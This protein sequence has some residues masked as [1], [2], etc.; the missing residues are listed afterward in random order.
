[1]TF[2]FYLFKLKCLFLLY[3]VTFKIV[4]YF[5]KKYY[6]FKRIKIDWAR[7]IRICVWV[8]KLYFLI[9]YGY[10][11]RKIIYSNTYFYIEKLCCESIVF[12][13]LLSTFLLEKFIIFKF[14]LITFRN[15]NFVK[16]E[17]VL[18]FL[19]LL[20]LLPYKTLAF[21]F[22]KVKIVGPEVVI[23]RTPEEEKAWQ[24]QGWRWLFIFTFIMVFYWTS[25]EFI[26]SDIYHYYLEDFFPCELPIEQIEAN[27]DQAIIR[28]RDLRTKTAVIDNMY[29]RKQDEHTK[30]ILLKTKAYY[31][32]MY[33][34]VLKHHGKP[35]VN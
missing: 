17:G 34:D 5:V 23:V 18:L 22:Y 35:R 7:F 26:W 8:F 29:L 16:I 2:I 10:I 33:D 3:R 11:I 20:V 15:E 32:Y 31:V 6:F 4:V 30:Q 28:L 25:W 1:M 27:S 24:R 12:S 14:Q 21:Q 13:K 9:V 19:H